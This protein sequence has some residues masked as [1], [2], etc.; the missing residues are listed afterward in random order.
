MSRITEALA[1]A[2]SADLRRS[3]TDNVEVPWQFED[4]AKN[5]V[6]PAQAPSAAP[7]SRGLES[8]TTT[9]THA[10]VL[11][12]SSNASP[13]GNEYSEKLIERLPLA[14]QSQFRKLGATLH[15]A[16]CER[17]VRSVMVSSA[18]PS[19]GKTLLAS[20]LALVLSQS[21]GRRVL[22]IDADLRQPS[23]HTAFG[24]GNTRGLSNWLESGRTTLLPVDEVSAG[25]SVLVAGSSQIDP[26]RI[27]VSDEM[28]RLLTD[29]TKN[30]D[31]LIVDT[32][33]VGLL[34][35]AHML[36]SMLDTCVLVIRAGKTPYPAVQKA[37]EIIG[38]ERIIGSILNEAAASQVT[39][40]GAA[41]D[42]Y[43]SH[44]SGR[45]ADSSL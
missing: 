45:G 2:E 38:R 24:L 5:E 17:G 28:R 16:Q 25:L 29:L 23:V 10:G 42:A 33:P 44:Y 34:P 8:P 32:P 31:W 12:P 11:R 35:D 3:Q 37:V 41:Y 40:Y 39:P 27:V 43:Y 14:A 13:V 6:E 18:L 36:A 15:Q 21:Y 19:E 30:Y 26:L 7:S 20:N 22:L 4:L 9:R 1:R